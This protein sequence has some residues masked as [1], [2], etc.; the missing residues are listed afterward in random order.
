[1]AYSWLRWPV[2]TVSRQEASQQTGSWCHPKSHERTTAYRINDAA[3]PLKD[4]DRSPVV[5]QIIALGC[6]NAHSHEGLGFRFCTCQKSK[7][8]SQLQTLHTQKPRWDLKW[9]TITDRFFLPGK[10]LSA[11]HGTTNISTGNL[12]LIFYAQSTFHM[13]ELMPKAIHCIMVSCVYVLVSQNYNLL[14]GSN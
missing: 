9:S 12:K 11:L 7:W 14:K 6:L 1:M 5:I 10:F 8:P 2:T 4:E 3:E 13:K